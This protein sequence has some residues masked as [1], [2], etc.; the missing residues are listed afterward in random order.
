MANEREQNR[1]ITLPPDSYLYLVNEGKGGLMT[2]HR[3]PTVVNQTGQDQPVR[4]DP[5]SR[6]YRQCKLEDAVMTCPRANEGDYVVLENPADNNKFPEQNSQQAIE[7][8]KGRRVILPGPWS[9]ALWPGQSATVIEGHRLR[10]NQYCVVIV[11]N[12]EEAAKNWETGTV[13]VTQTETGEGEEEKG[14]GIV[15]KP[16]RAEQKETHKKGLPKPESFAV[17]TRIIV[18]GSDV[19][20]FIPATGCEVQRDEN[21]K[22]VREAVTLEQLEYACLIDESGKKEYPRGPRVVFPRPTQVFEQ[23]RKQRRKFR[24]IELNN[25]NG[26]HLK[27]TADFEGPNYET[28]LAQTRKFKEGEELF[29]TG[30]TLSI[31]Y[32]REEFTIIEYGQGNRKHY[33]TAIPKGE[34]RY[35]I[36][37]ESGKIKLVTGPKML[38]PDPRNEILVR[39]ILSED[40][41]RLWYPGNEAAILYNRELAAAMAESPSGRSGVVSEGDWRKRQAR[42][43]A[44]A[45]GA[46]GPEG[47][48]MLAC[49]TLEAYNRPIGAQMDYSDDFEPEETGEQGGASSSVTR[50]T[51]YTQPRSLTL[52]T[53]FD[54]VPRIEIWPGYAVL[55]VGAE[56]SR[57][58]VEGPHVVLLEYDEKLGF[59]E[60]S[61]GKPKTTDKLY[62]TSYLCV[63]NNQVSDVIGFETKD[64]V[65]GTIKVSLRVNFEAKN[66][67]ERLKWFSV[68]NYVKLL[69]DHVRSIIAGMAKRNEV[70]DLKGDYVNLVRT[71]ILGAKPSTTAFGADEQPQSEPLKT[72]RPGLY[73][74]SNGMRV[75]EVEVLEL[76]LADQNISKMLDEAQHS[77]VKTNIELERARKDLAATK[78]KEGISQDKLRAEHDTTKLKRELEQQAVEEQVQLTLARIEAELKTLEKNKTKADAEEAVADLKKEREL[79]R[80]KKETD[81]KL[82]VDK[83]TLALKKDE[84]EATTGAACK[85]FEAAK[86][87]LYEVLVSLGRD[88][89]AA[90]LAEACTIERWLSGDSHMAS[91]TNL[92]S[93]SPVLKGFFDKA[94][95]IQGDGS[96]RRNRLKNPE[97]VPST[98]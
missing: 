85:R 36:E 90:R 59:M 35:V 79:A 46:G 47:K 95:E 27:V 91:I 96:G 81:H 88:D 89:M 11:Y 7:L 73:F 4:Y 75:V 57:K 41:C 78:E 6:T 74:E 55:V 51:K 62:K 60:L 76:T 69:T 40:E 8:K 82:E 33:S 14:E 44:A 45:A 72:S 87:G 16:V 34:G 63:Q 71:A 65:K 26:I 10:S 23:D 21:N 48:A 94:T 52:N 53:K 49:G 43:G 29:V 61:T 67:A 50:G 83:A 30:K 56:G 12:A 92:L 39:R 77:V 86:D 98:K 24:P 97:P 58:V 5:Q 13:A 28:D 93:I 54:G 32:P 66:D 20:F 37:R 3:G 2:V 38:L 19:S 1:D 15:V 80:A 25:I 17:G 18:R 64:H 22:Y 84:L 70:A 68:D 9:Q 42:G 31:Y